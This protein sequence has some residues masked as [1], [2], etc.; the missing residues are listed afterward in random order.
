MYNVSIITEN[1]MKPL[2]SEW[3]NMPL[4]K[5]KASTRDYLKG[6]EFFKGIFENSLS[7]QNTWNLEVAKMHILGMWI[8]RCIDLEANW[9]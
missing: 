7:T 8:P 2:S 1:S 6:V 3:K 4:L 5:S 9:I